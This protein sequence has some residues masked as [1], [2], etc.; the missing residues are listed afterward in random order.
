VAAATGVTDD[1]PF[2]FRI[3]TLVSFPNAA[4]MQGNGDDCRRQRAQVGRERYEQ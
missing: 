3:V 4:G 1:D 2:S